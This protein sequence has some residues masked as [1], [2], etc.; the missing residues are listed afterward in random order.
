MRDMKK[1]TRNLLIGV[2]LLVVVIAAYFIVQAV[3]NK[4]AE[5]AANADAQSA[6]GQTAGAE[7][8]PNA[9]AS[10]DVTKFT[11]T[12]PELSLSFVKED[13]TW[14]RTDDHEF[15]VYQGSVGAMVSTVASQS[16]ANVVMENASAE[17][18][19]RFGL[20]APLFKAAIETEDGRR[21]GILVGDV[22]PTGASA[23][24]CMDD[25]GDAPT[26]YL[27]AAALTTQFEY[28]EQDLIDRVYPPTITAEYVTELHTVHGDQEVYIVNEPDND[29]DLL[30]YNTWVMEKGF[31]SRM[32]A[33]T[34]RMN[35]QL[36]NY[37]SLVLNGCFDYKVT[38][39]EKPQ[40]GLD[41]PTA[42]MSISF[43]ADESTYS[44]AQEDPDNFKPTSFGLTFGSQD[45]NGNYYCMVDGSTGLYTMDAATVEQISFLDPYDYVMRLQALTN[46]KD[47]DSMDI[48]FGD[49]FHTMSIT[50]EFVKPEEDD[51]TKD[52]ELGEF[53][54]SKQNE[55]EEELEE[56]D[57]FFIDGREVDKKPFTAIY[58]SII[59]LTAEGRLDP[60]IVAAASEEPVFTCIFHLTEGR[61]DKVLNV[62]EYNDKYYRMEVDGVSL[63]RVAARSVEDC[64]KGY[65]Q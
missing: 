56:V 2:V 7:A 30:G 6:A 16:T 49:E 31:E 29:L 25:A 32:L 20:D 4:K 51:L 52:Q 13:G 47:I 36:P 21:R 63:F 18:L 11:Y 43:Y 57:T 58:T 28:K 45:E 33:N 27:G 59:G 60:E 34:D 14:Y 40:Y 37:A 5:E 12:N 8:D 22:D 54:L 10:T 41:N 15:P 55:D 42:T 62:Y 24:Y 38:D 48:T 19:A 44:A 61:P 50:R 46:I 1:K 64:M 9:I 3:N 26:I 39:E 35:A 23:Y 53:A 17:D 65:D